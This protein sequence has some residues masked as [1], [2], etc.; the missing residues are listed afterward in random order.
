[1]RPGSKVYYSR[2]FM[3]LLAGLIC[4]LIH[5]PLSLVVPLPLYDAIAILVA[6]ALYYV[7]ILLAKHV[8]GVKPDDLNNP[9]YLKR[10]GIFTFIMLWLMTWTLM[11]SFQTPLIP[12]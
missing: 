11:A 1:M 7:S 3:G 4:G 2:A 10:G 5:N 12:P 9:S 6:I 8:L